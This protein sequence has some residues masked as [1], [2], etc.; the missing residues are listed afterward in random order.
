MI[1]V[2]TPYRISLVGGGTDIPSVIQA[3][4]EGNIVSFTPK[5]FMHTCVQPTVSNHIRV[6]YT[7]TEIVPATFEGLNSLSH[8]IIR[9]ALYDFDLQPLEIVTVGD[10]PG[11]SGLGSSGA[12]SV[13]ILHAMETLKKHS[14]PCPAKILA[15]WATELEMKA[16]RRKIGYQDQYA[17]AY[18]GLNHMVFV[19]E[20]VESVCKLPDSLLKLFVETAF[21][22]PTGKHRNADK[23]LTAQTDTVNVDAYSAMSDLAVSTA[24]L[25][26]KGTAS[27]TDLTELIK[28]INENWNIKK[29]HY[30]AADKYC[31]PS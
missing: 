19:K 11:N 10:V 25:F 30:N 5:L 29:N 23:I 31:N 20:G 4:G 1:V 27:D 12:C 7:I 21:L 15:R 28:L 17:S 6:S 3:I 18:G 13:G 22:S 24:A 8:D 16:L 14:E 26:S 9:T 2:R